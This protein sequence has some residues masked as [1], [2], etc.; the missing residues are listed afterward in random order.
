MGKW[1]DLVIYRRDNFGSRPEMV[2]KGGQIVLCNTG[3]SN[4]SVPTVQPIYLRR[5]WGFQPKAAVENSL[6]FV[7]AASVKNG[8]SLLTVKSYGV[9]K[10]IVPVQHCRTVSKH[11]MKLNNAL[12]EVK[13]NPET[14]DVF[15]NGQLCTVPP[16]SELPLTRGTN[17]F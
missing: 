8:A 12:P 15:A 1:A 9:E 16:A 17:L 14:F 11:D 3:D 7:S 13:V 4:G 2:L 10:H 5:T 6:A